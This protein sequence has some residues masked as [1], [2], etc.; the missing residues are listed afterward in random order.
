MKSLIFRTVFLVSALFVCSTVRAQTLKFSP[1]VSQ[2]GDEAVT[3]ISDIWSRYFNSFKTAEQNSDSIRASLW[4]NGEPDIFAYALSSKDIF[5]NYLEHFTFS[6]RKN[7]DGFY[8]INT[9]AQYKPAP[10]ENPIIR[11]IY[12]VYA[13]EVNGQFKLF[14]YFDATKD[15]LNHRSEDGIDFYYPVSLNFDA[16]MFD[17]AAEFVKR[18]KNQY[19]IIDDNRITYITAN[20]MDECWSLLGASYTVARSDK[21]Y[22]GYSI[23]PRIILSSRP[24]HIHELVHAVM[25][26]LYPRASQLLHEGI[27]TY[28]GGGVNRDFEHHVK[29]LKKYIEN[30]DI[31]FTDF[32]ALQ[33]HDYL[34]GETI[35]LNTVGALL[36]KHT[37]QKYGTDKVLSLFDHSDLPL[38]FNE[39]G[40]KKE[41]INEWMTE[42]IKHDE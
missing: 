25:L 14:N 40:V 17:E 28:Y 20:D 11:K 29:N 38:I 7:S 2:S 6:I 5:Y 10:A 21:T 18:F 39:L 37:L 9:I 16:G 22:A 42:L 23:Q 32:E 34:Y 35:L 27:A 19:G 15:R 13:A 3:A 41:N 33:S 24:N 4:H 26:P 31:D 1:E 36:I 12:K 8:E 30:N